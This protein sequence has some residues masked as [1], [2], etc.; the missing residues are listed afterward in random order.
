[1][2]GQGRSNAVEEGMRRIAWAGENMPVL[3]GV[4]RRW[5]AERPLAGVRVAACLHVTTETANLV[6]AI[7][8]G[9]AEV[10][11]CASNPLS[12]QD[13]VAAALVQEHDLPTFACRGVDR[14]GYY[15]HIRAALEVRPHYTLDDG[16]DLVAALHDDRRDLLPEVRAGSE[17]TTTGVIRLRAM[18]AAG[19]LA[20]PIVAVNDAR[21]KHLFDNRHGT[22]QSTLDGIMR[23]TNRLLAG[24]VVVVAGYGWCGKGVA[25]RAAGLGA[26]VIVT[27]VDPVRALEAVMEGFEVAPMVDAAARGDVFVTVTGNRHVID[28]PHFARMKDGAIVANAGHFNVE[29]NL[30]ALRELAAERRAVKPG[31]E[32]FCLGRGRRIL[33]LSEGRLV[34]LAAAEGHPAQVMDMSFANQALVLEWLARERPALEPRV[35]PVPAAIDERVA[36]LK[37]TSMGLGIDRLTPE[38]EAYRKAWEHGTE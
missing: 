2:E 6:L 10:A 8:E 4:R 26:R 7:K 20:Y 18:A 17:E 38:Q 34:N 1:M 36:W 29:I 5:A 24:S 28:R 19:R 3:T 16:A 35:Y 32:E 31:V 13:D 25:M 30:E 11:L 14:D 27:E 23:A 33:V 9:G 21:T 15:R 22:G 12:T 37:L